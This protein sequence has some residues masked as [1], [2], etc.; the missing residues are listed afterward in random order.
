[1]RNKSELINPTCKRETSDETL[2][3]SVLKSTRALNC[4]QHEGCFVKMQQFISAD[5]Y[6]ALLCLFCHSVLPRAML[7]NSALKG[8]RWMSH[9]KNTKSKTVE[10]WVQIATVFYLAAATFKW[11]EFFAPSFHISKSIVYTNES[12]SLKIV[13]TE[14]WFTGKKWTGR[15]SIL[16]SKWRDDDC[17]VFWKGTRNQGSTLSVA[18]VWQVQ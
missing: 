14:M 4:H 16:T 15:Y 17:R 8:P 9:V 3:S 1:M 12:H 18:D 6:I 5:H 2:R 11:R 10:K 7:N 13:Y